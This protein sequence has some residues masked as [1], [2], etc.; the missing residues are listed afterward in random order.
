LFSCILST[1]SVF[2][3]KGGLFINTIVLNEKKKRRTNYN[4]F[5]IKEAA[6]SLI[7]AQVINMDIRD[8]GSRKSI[9]CPGHNDHSH[10]SCF[11]TEKGCHCFSGECNRTYDVLDMVML[12][13]NVDFREAA[14]IV[15]DLCGGRERFLLEDENIIE[16]IESE[17]QINFKLISRPDMELIGIYNSPVYVIRG[18]VNSYSEPEKLPGFRH[19]WYPGD[20]EIE[21]DDYV[22][23]EEMVVKSPLL[24]MLKSDPQVYAELIQNKAWEMLERYRDTQKYFF[25]CS[26]IDA[27]KLTPTIRR[28]EEII[29]EYGGSLR[30][31]PEFVTKEIKNNSQNKQP[32]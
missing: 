10:G 15:A 12:H 5:A 2:Q 19:T 18:I 23:I 13:C 17:E 6:D 8:Y 28:I 31:P 32:N 24:E 9:L 14:G 25:K 20:P 7:V 4:V 11:L 21:D 29:I 27:R 26:R 16:D 1:E 3:T 22:V 30:N